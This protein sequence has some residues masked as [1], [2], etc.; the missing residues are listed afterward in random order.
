LLTRLK[1]AL[2]VLAAAALLGPGVGVLAHRASARPAAADGQEAKKEPPRAPEA[3]AP[4]PPQTRVRAF[5]TFPGY[6]W[7]IG[8]EPRHGRLHPNWSVGWSAPHPLG[9]GGIV[10]IE[11]TDPNGALKLTLAY[12]PDGDK[13]GLARYRPVAFDARG[14]RHTLRQSFGGGA[15]GADGV[16]MY[17]WSLD[18]KVLP[19][20]QVEFL[21]IESLARGGP[22]V[23]ARE[24]AARAAKEGVEVPS[25]PQVGEP[26]AF[27]LTTADG[28]KISSRDLRGKV[29]LVDCWA[30]WCSPCV[31]LLPEIKALYEKWHGDGLEVVGISFD[32]NAG[33]AKAKCGELGLTW[34]QVI[35]PADD[36]TRTLWQE[37]AGIAILPRVLL[38]DREGILRAD[39]PVDLKA[40]V[41]RL[42]KRS[43]EGKQK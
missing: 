24:A 8:P 19:A 21:G 1:I 34:P 3:P 41:A 23:I 11:E 9:P 33:K 31:A 29:V 13:G 25:F 20:E 30:T 2:V 18:P 16:A 36:K 4:G 43:P 40:E 42:M 26:Y 5:P 10:V 27:T 35:V 38:I 6:W 17:R 32:N 12:K 28:T 22:R 15:G 14:K 7:A 37:A 39:D